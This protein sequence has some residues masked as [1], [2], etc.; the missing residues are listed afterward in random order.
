[1]ILVFRIF[2]AIHNNTQII[3]PKTD[4]IRNRHHTAPTF[5]QY[6]IVH[7]TL[8]VAARSRVWV[9]GRSPAGFTS[10][11]PTGDMD[12]SLLWMSCVVVR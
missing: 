3:E 11:N 5:V 1:M 10:S 7:C 6:V 2:R 8:V 9:C 4:R 12:V